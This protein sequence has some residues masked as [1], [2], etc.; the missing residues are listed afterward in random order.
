[1]SFPLGAR[2]HKYQFV[3]CGKNMRLELSAVCLSAP[4]IHFWIRRIYH[5]LERRKSTL[6]EKQRIKT[7]RVLRISNLLIG[8]LETQRPSSFS[9]ISKPYN[10]L[11]FWAKLDSATYIQERSA[12][13]RHGISEKVK[14]MSNQGKTRIVMWKRRRVS[15]GGTE[16]RWIQVSGRKFQD[17]KEQEQINRHKVTI[18]MSKTHELHFWSMGFRG[19][20]EKDK[21]GKAVKSDFGGS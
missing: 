11:P 16:F 7:K 9:M 5:Y 21:T 3:P 13:M 2:E 14:T 15:Q 17:K 19:G 12:N 10:Q 8:F 1:M 4:G 20:R 18:T 6:I